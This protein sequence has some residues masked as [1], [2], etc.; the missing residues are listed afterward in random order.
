MSTKKFASVYVPFL[1][2][3]VFVI[4]FSDPS[5]LGYMVNQPKAAPIFLLAIASGFVVGSFGL[6]AVFY[7]IGYAFSHMFS[8]ESPS[9]LKT[10][11]NTHMAIVL[12]LIFGTVGN[13]LFPA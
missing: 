5:G 10:V 6:G 7:C 8:R 1:I 3:G 12:L 4:A 11:L 2:A 9:Y 13:M